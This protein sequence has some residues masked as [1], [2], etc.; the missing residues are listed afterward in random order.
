[1]PG[2]HNKLLLA[3]ILTVL[4]FASCKK[5]TIFIYGIEDVDVR[6]NGGNKQNLKNEIEFISIAY[7]DI[8]GTSPSQSML[9][10]LSLI[11][12]AFGDKKLL[13]DLI[14]KNM[15]NHAS[16]QIPSDTQMRSNVEEFVHELY[17]RLYNRSPDEFEAWKLR[18]FI[19]SDPN[20]NVKEI[21]YAMMTADEYR[22]Y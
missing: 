8:F 10:Q 16:A 18:E 7:N 2:F 3:V 12:L 20:L 11:Y 1:M 22:Y 21:Y 14:I 17:L 15:L 9:S 19:E 4:A 13:E 5:E 6:R